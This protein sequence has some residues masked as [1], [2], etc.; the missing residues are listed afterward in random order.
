MASYK[1]AVPS[2]NPGGLEARRSDHFGHADLFTL[3]EVEDDKV[4][5]VET[6]GSVEHA[7]GGCMAPVQALADAGVKRMI[8]GGMG[9]RPLAMCTQLGVRVY[10]ANT[11]EHPFVSDVADAFTAGKLTVMD[12]SQACGGGAACDH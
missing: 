4:I 1:I 5:G 2:D 7:S 8:V 3:L 12:D 6:H 11:N 10:F 9:G